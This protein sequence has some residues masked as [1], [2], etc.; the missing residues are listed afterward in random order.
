MNRFFLFLFM[1]VFFFGCEQK[2]TS[3][4]VGPDISVSFAAYDNG[5]AVNSRFLVDFKKEVLLEGIETL[6]YLNPEGA[7]QNLSLSFEKEGNFLIITPSFTLSYNQKYELH[8]SKNLSFSD[9]TTLQK[10]Y[11]YY[12][13][14]AD[15]SDTTKPT[16]TQST[17][18]NS[19]TNAS[20]YTTISL[21]HSEAINPITLNSNTV[22]LKNSNGD[23]I[24][25]KLISGAQR[26]LIKPLKALDYNTS[27]TLTLSGYSDLS[28]NLLDTQ[29]LSF[30]TEVTP[31]FS[32]YNFSISSAIASVESYK[33]YL[34]FLDGTN[35][36]SYSMSL[37]NFNVADTSNTKSVTGTHR[38]L[39]RHG[40]YLY[41]AHDA[42]VSVSSLAAPSTPA[43]PQSITGYINDLNV[44]D[45][46]FNTNYGVF[47]STIDNNVSFYALNTPTDFSFKYE[48]NLSSPSACAMDADN[49]A[50]CMGS[51]TLRRYNL[52]SS[53]LSKADLYTPSGDGIPSNV[54]I[55][56]DANHLFFTDI[57]NLSDVIL[58][59]YDTSDK[60]NSTITQE[61]NITLANFTYNDTIY[62]KRYDN[63]LFAA[64]NISSTVYVIDISDPKALKIAYTF[65]TNTSGHNK[66]HITQDNGFDEL[67]IPEF[68]GANFSLIPIDR[69]KNMLD[70]KSLTTASKPYVMK[71]FYD[72][73]SHPVYA[74]GFSDGVALYDENFTNNTPFFSYKTTAPVRD[75]SIESNLNATSYYMSLALGDQGVKLLELN[76]L[77]KG[78]SVTN[79]GSISNIGTIYSVYTHGFDST[80]ISGGSEGIYEHNITAGIDKAS[81]MNHYLNNTP[82]KKLYFNDPTLYALPLDTSDFSIYR[83]TY[84]LNNGL[85]LS[86]LS[87]ITTSAYVYDVFENNEGH[88]FVALGEKGV[89]LY[90]A[91]PTL[92]KTIKTPGFAK[93]LSFEYAKR[94]TASQ[95]LLGGFLL[96][97]DIT[98]VSRIEYEHNASSTGQI[99]SAQLSNF[100]P[101][102]DDGY[103]YDAVLG[104][105]SNTY[106]YY[107]NYITS[108]KKIHQVGSLDHD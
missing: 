22:S 2:P 105:D 19:D 76:S 12:F 51:S 50:Y 9:H 57:Y 23:L 30:T 40:N 56:K 95:T 36:L 48:D 102:A 106:T 53:T 25:A 21:T 16:L 89:A 3:V 6:I 17:P 47:S 84:N 108:D 80:L 42:T 92:F 33:G 60:S 85:S 43:T 37:Q 96:I 69:I 52:N 7:D 32:D 39:K 88:L 97:A 107:V 28:A 74:V 78:V 82:I 90:S 72:A 83:F 38:A 75:I 27:Y 93:S 87:T 98:G 91:G 54:A 73:N 15:S 24:A 14:S 81:Q 68:L 61:S 62:L 58:Y 8:F 55:S 100:T 65:T 26:L 66:I 70:K 11:T 63:L 20:I 4:S 64:S 34:Y 1:I 99:I 29:T 101:Y 71:V 31:S 5:V 18:A 67:I 46:T 104:Y 94:G 10:D 49:Y 45:M 77:L 13:T 103:V 41:I 44:T 35:L 86:A 79:Q 59:A